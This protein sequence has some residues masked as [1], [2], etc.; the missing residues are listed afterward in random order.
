MRNKQSKIQQQR[1]KKL[2]LMITFFWRSNIFF[3]IK[4][5]LIFLLTLAYYIIDLLMYNSNITSYLEFDDMNDNLCNVYADSISIFVKLKRELDQYEN[6]YINCNVIKN[7]FTKM[8]IPRINNVTIPKFG[9]LIMQISR[10]ADFKKGTLKKFINLYSNNACEEIMEYSY[11]L[12]SCQNFW[13]GVLTKGM[14]QAI[15]QMGVTIGTVIDE[16]QALNDDT[17]IKLKYLIGGSAFIEYEQF[18]QYYLF[19]SYTKT[20][21]IFDEFRTEKMKT[22][23]QMSRIILYFYLIAVALLFALFYYFLYQFTYLFN[24]FLNFIAILPIKYISEDENF[25]NEIIKYG[26]KYY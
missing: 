22:I 26:E 1:R 5:I 13:S 9:N 20:K 8:E 2:N 16:L 3:L 10:N 23:K 15:T 21:A 17:T 14:E 11:Q 6:N 19:K 24:S 4:I 25:Y 12:V 7:G 18:N